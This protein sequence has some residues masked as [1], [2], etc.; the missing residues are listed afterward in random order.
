MT[1]AYADGTSG[2]VDP[3]TSQEAAKA[4]TKIT[5]EV[6]IDVLRVLV[7][8]GRH[9]GTAKEIASDLG[10]GDKGRISTALTNMYIM[11]RVARLNERRSHHYVHVLPKKVEGR[12]TIPYFPQKAHLHSDEAIERAE[13]LAAFLDNRASFKNPPS[14]IP[15]DG[16]HELARFL[17]GV[18]SVS[19]KR[20]KAT[21]RR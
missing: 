5:D 3:D 13:K 6:M 16:D 14:L 10:R 19:R 21:T 11:G 18:A 1:G 4:R 8:R 9:G 17:R 20:R 15:Q 7:V 12:E 2:S